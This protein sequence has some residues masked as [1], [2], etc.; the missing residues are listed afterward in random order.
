MITSCGD[1]HQTPGQVTRVGGTQGGVGQ[2]LAGTVGGDE[3]LQHR[4]ALAE[5]GLDRPRDDLT[6]GVGH[7]AAHAGDLAELHACSRERP[8][9]IIIQIGLVLRERRPPSPAATS[10][11]RPWSRSR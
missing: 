11:G 10:L 9:W 1:V 7:Q 2:T 5:G 3:V 6:L 4:Q 8:S